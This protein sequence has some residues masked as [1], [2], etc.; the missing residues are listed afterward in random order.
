MIYRKPLGLVIALLLIMLSNCGKTQ[1]SYYPLA[2][3][4]VWQYQMSAGS[5][6]QGATFVITNLPERKLNGKKVV[7]Q[8][9]ELNNT[10]SFSFLS[11][12]KDGLYEIAVQKPQDLEPNV[13]EPP[14]KVIPYPTEAGQSWESREE[15]ILT[16]PVSVTLAFSVESV[17]EEVTVPAGTFSNCL[18]VVGKGSKSF[19]GLGYGIGAYTLNVEHYRWYAPGTGLVR[20]VI[21]EKSNDVMVGSVEATIQLMSFK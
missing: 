15:T 13:K 21:R 12:E 19:K 6:H 2:K 16:G 1:T 7:P 8:Q 10:T 20:A 11:D 17:D 5:S 9:V 18:K 14:S 3:G 4:H